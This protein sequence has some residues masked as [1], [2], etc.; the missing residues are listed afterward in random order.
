LIRINLLSEARA[1]AA[2]K[3]TGTAP[4]GAR[5]NNLILLGGVAVGIL[6]IGVM[7]LLLTSRSRHL[8]EE[9][10]KAQEEVARLRSIID[11]VKGYELKKA[12]LESKIQLINNLK[13]NQR[14]PVRLMDEISRA[15]PDLVWLTEL[16]V[17][18]DQ[19]TLKGRTLSPN[20]VATYLENLK[21]SPFFAEPVF[22]NLGR[23]AGSQ[24][25]YVWEMN[26]T[27][28]N[29]QALAVGAFP[30]GANPPGAVPPTPTPAAP[31]VGL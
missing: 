31:P 14:G 9:I 10:A 17:A 11:E 5:L 7:A 13:T 8:D 22:R 30:P 25:L 4:T 28:T 23:E 6:Y 15:L 20:A 27:F 19:V 26:L 16:T 2:R 18:G 12:S 21:K 3:K 29:A 1:A 24:G